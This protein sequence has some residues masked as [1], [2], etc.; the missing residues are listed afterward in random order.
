MGKQILIIEDDESIRESMKNV[1]ELNGFQV[2]VAAD[3]Q[4]A[5]QCLGTL[6]ELPCV[7]LLDM[8]MPG[9]NGWQFLDFQRANPKYAGIPV[10]V[11]TALK[12]TAHTV[13]ASAILPK[14]V[15]LKLLI[16]AVKAFC[17]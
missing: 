11:C 10:I 17:S 14:P 12:A 16:A 6:P 15:E 8:M 7:I 9:M 5:I 1:L 13:R 4:E 3:G 2:A